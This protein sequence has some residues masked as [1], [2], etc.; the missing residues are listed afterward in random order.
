MLSKLPD[1]CVEVLLN[2][3]GKA[4]AT[5][6]DGE[7]NVVPVS[8]IRVV[9]GKIQLVNY[10]FGKTLKNITKDENVSLAVWKGLQGYQ[11]KATAQ[12]ETEGDVFT[13]ITAWIKET[14]P[15]RV[16]KGVLILTPT[17]VYDVSADVSRAGVVVG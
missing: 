5:C 8:S 14:I 1:E 9:E 6:G 13:E 4:L 15:D 7:I 11:I 17:K 10:F 3:T 12:Y 2:A 16:V